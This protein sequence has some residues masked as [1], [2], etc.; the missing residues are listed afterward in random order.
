MRFFKCIHSSQTFEFL[1]FYISLNYFNRRGRCRLLRIGAGWVNLKNLTF[2][3]APVQSFLLFYF[4][5]EEKKFLFEYT[6]LFLYIYSIKKE[7][8]VQLYKFVII[9]PRNIIHFISF[10]FSTG[11][12]FFFIIFLP[13]SERKKFTCLMECSLFSF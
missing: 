5:F 7:T 9:F 1:L 6:D 4:K 11:F 3:K 2:L 10:H 8:R 13:P 12:I